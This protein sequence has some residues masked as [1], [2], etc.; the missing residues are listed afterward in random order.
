LYLQNY[1]NIILKYMQKLLTFWTWCLQ[2]DLH[3]CA[4]TPLTP[5]PVVPEK[6]GSN[7]HPFLCVQVWRKVLVRILRITNVLKAPFFE[8]IVSKFYTN[9]ILLSTDYG[10]RYITDLYNYPKQAFKGNL[11]S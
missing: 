10:Y 6:T 8:V 11:T 9:G 2:G 7:S 3:P 4:I 1:K 5:I